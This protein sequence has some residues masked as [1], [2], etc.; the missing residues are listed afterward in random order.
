MGTI[1]GLRSPVFLVAEI[2]GQIFATIVLDATRRYQ[3]AFTIFIGCFLASALL[4]YFAH[5]P[6]PVAST[7]SLEAADD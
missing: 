6:V 2:G 3:F 7:P 5:P 1:Y 4:L